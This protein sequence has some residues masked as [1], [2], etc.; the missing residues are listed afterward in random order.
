MVRETISKT[1]YADLAFVV[2]VVGR[3][4]RPFSNR[5]RLLSD[6]TSRGARG[7]ALLDL[8]PSHLDRARLLEYI[9]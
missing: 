3:S 6:L 1:M 9:L 7:L 4:S 2:S 8:K 5:L